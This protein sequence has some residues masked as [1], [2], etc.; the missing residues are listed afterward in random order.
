MTE[1]RLSTV[2]ATLLVMG[3]ILGVGI[4]FTPSQVAERAY[5]PWA[6]LAMWVIG[7]GFALA[8][9][10][11]F[12]EWG[13]SFP[14]AGGWYVFLRESFGGL[15]AF[16][17]AWVVLFVI[18]TGA[19]ASV[20][21]FAARAVDEALP[22]YDLEAYRGWIA[23]LAIVGV[24][25][26]CLAGARAGA[27]FQN[28]LMA[29]KL[30][31]IGCLLVAGLALATP[32]AP[33]EPVEASGVVERGSLWAGMATALLPV[34]FAYG[35]WQMVCYVAPLVERPE[36]TL[37]RAIVGGVLGVIVIYLALAC[38]YLRVLGIDRLASDAGFATVLGNHVFGTSGGALLSAGLAV[39]ALGWLVVTIFGSPWLYVA[40]AREGLFLPRFARLS[41][42]GAPTAGLLLQLGLALAYLA[43]PLSFLVD[44]VVSAEW[45]FH[46]LVA[47]GLLRFRRRNP[48]APRPFRSPLYPLAPLLYLAAAFATTLSQ[49]TVGE[50][51]VL[52]VGAA[53][54]AAGA[55]VY[56]L[57]HRRPL[58]P[59]TTPAVTLDEPDLR[60]P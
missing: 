54:I 16:L 56:A 50:P 27:T 19:I 60:E 14:K 4:F 34:F 41:G 23:A 35:G 10:L 11:T 53:V 13:A 22:A 31:A 48:R 47:W 43:L 51:R 3:G 38:A 57:W 2:D 1:R 9:A 8:A 12:A 29:A 46:G 6:F 28:V 58:V 21:S 15:A 59:A 7:G 40:M 26:V 20:A 49:L 55:L 25:G 45:L 37:P 18:S 44:A 24:T 33:L 52:A 17:F 5:E 30:G 39:S 42:R 36:R 32:M